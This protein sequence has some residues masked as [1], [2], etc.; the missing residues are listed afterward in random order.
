LSIGLY[1]IYDYIWKDNKRNTYRGLGRISTMAYGW[2]W[3]TDSSF[4]ADYIFDMIIDSLWL[5]PVLAFV[6]IGII[7][8]FS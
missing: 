1:G 5:Y 4:I 6:G 3:F 7:Y 8:W 2:S